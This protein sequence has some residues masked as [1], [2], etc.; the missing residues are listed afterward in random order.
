MN[1]FATV[2]SAGCIK[3]AGLKEQQKPHLAFP[4]IH[5]HLSFLL[6]LSS[7]SLTDIRL[8]DSVHSLTARIKLL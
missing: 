8:M 2:N 5:E 3:R 1:I 6:F 7:C 4:G